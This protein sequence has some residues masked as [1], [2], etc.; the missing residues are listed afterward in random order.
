MKLPENS[1]ENRI[2]RDARKNPYRGS[3][4]PGVEPM[5]LGG[6]W[7]WIK[8]KAGGLGKSA[9]CFACD[10]LPVGK[11]ICRRIARC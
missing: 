1:N 3:V 7:D 5:F 11:D 2:Y 10:R 4:M 8:K 9:A 6:A